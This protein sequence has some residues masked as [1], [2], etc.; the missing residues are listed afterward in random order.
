MN[1]M[2]MLHQLKSGNYARIVEINVKEEILQRFYLK[3]IKEGHIVRVIC[4]YHNLIIDINNRIFAIGY[5]I[6]K[7][8]R[9]I[10]IKNHKFI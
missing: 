2:T 4:S 3:N 1:N 10:H 5:D 7:E 9:I 8:I 6:A